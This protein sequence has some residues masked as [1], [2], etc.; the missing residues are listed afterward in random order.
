MGA[1]VLVTGLE[2]CEIVLLHLN[3]IFILVCLKWL[4]VF[5]SCGEV[6]VKVAQCVCVDT[7]TGEGVVVGWLFIVFFVLV[8]LGLRGGCCCCCVKFVVSVVVDQYPFG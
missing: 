5:L 2:S 8:V 3:A 1:S 4:V 7:G 6:Y